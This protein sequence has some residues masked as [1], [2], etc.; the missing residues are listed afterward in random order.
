MWV[1]PLITW[2]Y[3]INADGQSRPD[4]IFGDFFSA[5]NV[6]IEGLPSWASGRTNS[7][8][9]TIIGEAPEDVTKEMMMGPMM[10]SLLE[11]RF[12]LKIHT[13]TRDVPGYELHVAKGGP[14][15]PESEDAVCRAFDPKHPGGRLGPESLP[16]CNMQLAGVTMADF[17]AGMKGPPVGQPVVD[18]TGLKGAFAIHMLF[19]LEPGDDSGLPTYFEALKEQLGLELVPAKETDRVLVVDHI[20]EP[21]PN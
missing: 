8:R 3:A 20:E 12:H 16:N 4:H 2:A 14:K 7:E 13:E 21:T 1:R 9:F 17:A 18:E 11:D 10:Q 5:Y 6:S 19:T 15:L